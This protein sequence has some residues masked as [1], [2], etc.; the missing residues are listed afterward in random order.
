MRGRGASRGQANLVAVAVALVLVTSVLG[1]SVVVAESVLVSATEQRDTSDR[2]AATTLAARLLA[3]S[4]PTYPRGVVENRT[5][6]TAAEVESLAPAVSDAAVHVELD[7]RTLFERGDATAGETVRRG[8]VVTTPERRARSI[9]LSGTETTTLTGR[10][11]A[12][13]LTLRPGPNTTVR[14]V[15]VNGRVV[16][17]NDSGL[18]GTTTVRTSVRR[19][20]E[21]QFETETSRPEAGPRGRV[22]VA[23]TA[24]GGES[25]TLVVSVD[26]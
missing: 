8:V 5:T 7:G 2:Y 3:D 18:S 24:F 22:D 10:T 17:H 26:G 12:V 13:E 1:T 11:T 19:P 6:L 21:L 23:Y 4:P 15:R 9:D 20:T 14:T 16:L 25:T